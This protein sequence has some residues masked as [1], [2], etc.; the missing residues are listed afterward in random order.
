MA[1][2]QAREQHVARLAAE[3]HEAVPDG[4]HQPGIRRRLRVDRR[5]RRRVQIL[6]RHQLLEP[7]LQVYAQ[8][9][10][11]LEALGADWVQ[12]DEPALALDLRTNLEA[13]L[14]TDEAIRRQQSEGFNELPEAPSASPLKL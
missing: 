6:E 13:G 9:L 8:V 11:R 12:L 1:A 5:L 3:S 2:R 4:A 10:R 7:L 14:S